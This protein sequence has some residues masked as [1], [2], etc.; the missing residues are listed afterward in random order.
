MKT[1]FKKG[2]DWVAKMTQL[3]PVE[4]KSDG[5]FFK[6]ED[7]FAPF[8]Y[9][10]INGS[11]LRQ[12][13]WLVS[14]HVKSGKGG[15]LFS[16]A[17]VLSPQL[18][19]T[20][21]VAKYFGMDAVHVIGAS[22]PE[23]AI[24]KPMVHMATQYGASFYFAK[25]GYNPYIQNKVQKLLDEHT[26]DKYYLNY[27]ITVGDNN[28]AQEIF[29]FHDLGGL[30]VENI[31]DQ[32][33]RL[34]VPSGSC[35][36]TISILLGLYLDYKKGS[37]LKDVFLCGIGPDKLKLINHR[38]GK[39]EELLGVDDIRNDFFGVDFDSP[40]GRTDGKAKINLQY[41]NIINNGYTT[42]DTRVKSN[43][44]DITFHPTY[45]AK[46]HAW[47]RA[48]MP[49]WYGEKTLFWIV[50]SEPKLNPTANLKVNVYGSEL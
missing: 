46:V 7:Y 29:G 6:R 35:N 11:K 37:K 39:I 47:T 22:K 3:T 28:D 10:G 21:A 50:G 32:V 43:F 24:N 12:C 2:D 48:N 36:S 31:P 42:Y 17:S 20:T 30:Q 8:G 44:D 49:E 16:A 14:E 18:P 34:I 40:F 13:I 27:G 26:G 33:E 4:Q 19:M 23:T 1:I 5:T 41:T 9:G 38:L 25:V 15:T 45:E